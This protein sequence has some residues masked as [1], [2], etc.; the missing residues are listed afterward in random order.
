[1]ETRRF[2]N[3]LVVLALGV[4]LG[5]PVR[6]AAQVESRFALAPEEFDALVLESFTTE[7]GLPQNSVNAL[8]QDRRGF[9]WLATFGGIAHFDGV[10][11]TIHDVAN[12]P[13]MVSNRVLTLYE[14][15]AEE[16]W[17]GYQFGGIGRMSDGRMKYYGQASG[18]PGTSAWQIAETPDGTMWV[19]TD[20]GLYNALRP[21]DGFNEVAMPDNVQM[22]STRLFV[23]SD[24]VFVA[25]R[26]GVF[27]VVGSAINRRQFVPA[28]ELLGVTGINRDSTGRFWV[29]SGVGVYREGAGK[30]LSLQR[31]APPTDFKWGPVTTPTG[32]VWLLGRSSTRI[33][34][35]D[36]EAENINWSRTST[37]FSTHPN[38]L[39]S[40]LADAEGTLW[41]GTRGA[42]LL[43][44]RGRGVRHHHF[45]MGVRNENVLAVAAT[46]D[47]DAIVASCPGLTRYGN[48]EMVTPV[49]IGPRGRRG[50]VTALAVTPEGTIWFSHLGRISRLKGEE[51]TEYGDPSW[52]GP[53]PRA[54]YLENEAAWFPSDVGLA[55][56]EDERITKYPAPSGLWPSTPPLFLHRDRSGAFWS[57]SAEGLY[58]FSEGEYTV[59]GGD[60]L[61]RAPARDVYEDDSG[62]LWFATYGNGLLRYKDGKF[63]RFT[64]ADGLFDNAISAVEP[65]GEG[66]LWLNGN[67]GVF[68]VKLEDLEAVNRGERDQVF[69][70]AFSPRDGAAEGSGGY[71]PSG[72]R[73]KDGRILFTSIEGITEVD[74]ATRPRNLTPP[75]VVI[76]NVLVADSVISGEPRV[77]PPRSRNIEVRYSGLSLLRPERVRFRYRLTPYEKEWVEAGSRREAFYTSIPPGKYTFELLA[78]NDEGIW[79]PEPASIALTVLPSFWATWWFRVIGTLTVL[80]SMIQA[81]RRRTRAIETRN[82]SLKSEIAE[83]MKVEQQLRVTQFSVD[84]AADSVYWMSPEGTFLYIN[85]AACRRLGYTADEVL[86]QPVA[87]ITPRMGDNEEWKAMIAQLRRER[88]LEVE[89]VHR[90]KDGTSVDVEITA[91]WVQFGGSEY[92]F[93]FARDITMRKEAEAEREHLIAELESK[94]AELERF[95]Y[96]VSH[97]LKSPLVTIKG[98]LGLLKKDALAGNH[99]RVED[100]VQKIGDAADKMQRLLNELLELSRIGRMI[101]PVEKMDFNLVVADAVELLRGRIIP[102][103]IDVRIQPNLPTVRGDRVRLTEVIQNLVENAVKFMA[104]QTDP[105]I[106]IGVREGGPVP[107]FFVSDNGMGIDPEYHQQVFGLFD[108]LSLEGEGTGIGLA[109]VQRIIQ[110]HGGEIWV[111]SEGNGNG[112]IF[113]FTLSEAE[114]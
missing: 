85:E 36:L 48:G 71:S 31:G 6:A 40:V 66:Y 113:A 68:A 114:A 98:F 89:S 90:R 110:T 17:I 8:V 73:L 2:Q 76:E 99:A 105:R 111:E 100:D 97:D 60:T 102:D 32:E 51:L 78:A 77:I 27:E 95:T 106:E 11:F 37:P 84:A 12:T 35:A 67:R 63:R 9:L 29:T 25:G 93:A 44:V 38:P 81:I 58:R 54:I 91:T 69:S 24:T 18:L 108:R 103:G 45:P 5:T 96:T 59:I 64:T 7:Q 65:D 87:F 22:G 15:Q 62:V 33:P 43:K 1:V 19:A 86:G 112:S 107:V 23:S 61:S 56:I 30:I 16:I 74:P 52:Y 75:P 39:T 70:V 94:N 49:P 72:T 10:E 104:G 55:K 20:R 82:R 14:S 34:S 26:G 83:R 42:G 79:T 21:E 41:L 109:L 101:N 3:A 13:G 57:G 28:R 80:G 88:S 4:S 47:G 53:P 92:V 46:P 50:C